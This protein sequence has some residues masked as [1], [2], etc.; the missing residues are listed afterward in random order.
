MKKILLHLALIFSYSVSNAQLNME[1]GSQIDYSATLNDVW[2]WHDENGNEY[3][4][5][6]LVNGVSIVEVTDPYNAREIAN[7]PGIPSTWRDIKSWKDHAY[8]S[9]ESGD[10]VTVIDMSNLPG[11]VSAYQWEPDIPGLGKLS[12]IHN[13]FVDENGI[14]YLS[15]S[16][17]NSGGAIYVDVDTDPSNPQVISWGPAIYNHD[18]YARGDIMY[19]S[20]IN[21]GEFAVYDISDKRNTIE[22]ARQRTPFNFT[23]N[24]WLSDNSQVLFTTDE[25]RNAS[26]AAYDISDLDDIELLDEYRPLTSL[27]TGTIPHNVHTLNDYLIISY[28]TDGGRVVDASRPSNLIEVGNFDS[29]FGANGGSSGVWGAY[30]FLPSRTVL[31]SDR[32]NGLVVTVPTYKRACWLEGTVTEKGSGIALSD[33]S[34]E[35]IS[36]QVNSSTTANNGTY[37]TGQVLSGDFT[38]T[39]QKAGY[40]PKAVT[41][42]LENGVLT[43]LNVELE[44]S[45]LVSITGTVYDLDSGSPLPNANVIMKDFFGDFE[46]VTNNSGQIQ[47]NNVPVGEYELFSG[48]WGYQYSNFLVDV[49]DGA[50]IEIEL[51]RGYIDDFLFDYG[52][53]PFSLPTVSSGHW[54]RGIP[55]STTLMDGTPSAPNEDLPGDFGDNCY[56]TGIGSSG[57]PAGANDVDGGNVVLTSPSIDLTIYNVPHIKFSYWFVNAEGQGTPNDFLTVRLFNGVETATILSTSTSDGNWIDFDLSLKDKL[58]LTSDMR[59]VFETGDADPGHIVEAAIDGFEIYESDNDGDGFGMDDCN[60]QNGSINPDA[61]EIPNNPIDEDCDGIALI[62]DDDMDG[63]NSDEDCDDT[64][65]LVNPD[66]MEI[67]NNTI[68]EDCDG[69]A[70]IIDDDM[71]GFNSDED[72]DDTNALVNPDAMEIPNNTIDEDCDGIALIIDDDM[73]G[74]N[75]DDDCDDTNALI[76]PDAMEIPNNQIDEDCDGIALIIDDD[77]DGFNSDDDCD[78]NNPDI[79]PDATE[80]PNNNIDEDCNGVDL[81]ICPSVETTGAGPFCNQNAT[82]NLNDLTLTT[83]SGTWTIFSSPNGAT[84]S[85]F[86]NIFDATGSPAG[87][88]HLQFMLNSPQPNCPSSS[89]QIILIFEA[90]SAGTV[91]HSPSF[92]EG[93][94]TTISLFDLIENY[95]VGGLWTDLSTIPVGIDF[96]SNNGT[97]YLQRLQSG[98]Y[99]FQYSITDQSVCPDDF[100]EVVIQ[101]LPIIDADMDGFNSDEDCDDLN[102]DINPNAME[103]PNNNIDEDCDGIALV[104]DDDMDGFNSDEDCNDSNPDINPDAIEI[105]NNGID[106]DCDGF[107]TVSSLD[108]S[109]GFDIFQTMP[110]PFLNKLKIVH[111]YKGDMNIVM[112]NMSGQIV[113][114]K[115]VTNFNS[116]QWFEIEDIPSG[117]YLVQVTP[118][119]SFKIYTSKMMKV[120]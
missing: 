76:N 23:H 5:V 49:R 95:D 54:E 98:R 47:L 42:T 80:I 46:A 43:I 12:S 100:V 61:M 88:Y 9:N 71:D 85:I 91:S 62:I 44:P 115:N 87:E 77:M 37:E 18:I 114:K 39:F 11:S 102:P 111:S 6:G 112:K 41:A 15:G 4:I 50:E 84:A 92:V 26:V 59:L 63:F 72:C 13:L 14:L 53:T 69:I 58:P 82:I 97:L 20:E 74:F 113:W 34:V 55:E 107:D 73:D 45:Q 29:F 83:E 57:E 32:Q 89:T 8:V 40:R 105:P 36:D 101:I 33:V 35:I 99:V 106:E 1:L 70:L 116:E 30:P 38:V 56:L 60:D 48:S 118:I 52:W 103:I 10:G 66:A 109:S 120:D 79:N 2:G 93:K 28:Y 16:N 96:N 68:D 51:E 21:R 17:L 67:P 7:I 110:N 65:A 22:L 27:G 25:R 75:S 117:I 94:D 119:N 81:I 86:T 3:A 90:L 104:I 24:A 108:H 31:L 19:T 78:D 64:N